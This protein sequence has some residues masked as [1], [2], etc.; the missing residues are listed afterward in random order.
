M[1]NIFA[2]TVIAI[3]ITCLPAGARINNTQFSTDDETGA[4]AVMHHNIYKNHLGK[5]YLAGVSTNLALSG[6]L[7]ISFRTNSTEPHI[8]FFAD[9]SG[10]ANVA[11]FENPTVTVSTGSQL[12]AFNQ[13]RTS[14]NTTG[15]KEATTG[16]YVAGNL[17]L[18]ATVSGGT[19][20]FPTY[21]FGS[22]KRVGGSGGFDSEYILKPNEDYALVVTSE[23][24]DNDCSIQL[25][26]YEN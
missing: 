16:T 3:F 21:H 6:T 12:T 10:G 15:L 18:D 25:T 4:I 24:A 8:T 14:S 17:A 22:G 2:L 26:W 7:K 9:C 11:G 1:K 23:A 5:K 20:I 19:A 13:N